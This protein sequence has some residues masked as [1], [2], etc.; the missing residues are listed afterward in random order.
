MTTKMLDSYSLRKS[1]R[2]V[3]IGTGISSQNLKSKDQ[4]VVFGIFYP[5][6]KKFQNGPL[7]I[8]IPKSEH[9]TQM[10]CWFRS[11]KVFGSKISYY[12]KYG[13][14]GGGS[15]LKVQGTDSYHVNECT[16]IYYANIS[17][18]VLWKY[19]Q[20]LTD[21]SISGHLCEWEYKRGMRE[22]PKISLPLL[23]F[24]CSS[25]IIYNEC[26]FCLELINLTPAPSR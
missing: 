24:Y 22:N 21:I 7:K 3:I 14:W 15:K 17:A 4:K 11:N 2:L 12:W 8:K 9:G 5:S 23:L 10:L 16:Y 20:L 25:P 13:L 18:Q 6:L 26:I 1:F 19:A